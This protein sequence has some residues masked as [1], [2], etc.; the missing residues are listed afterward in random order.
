[1]IFFDIFARLL[2]KINVLFKKWKIQLKYL[3]HKSKKQS[4]NQS[5]KQRLSQPEHLLSQSQLKKLEDD[6]LDPR[7]KKRDR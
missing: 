1:L 4:P 2:G 7:I 3:S 6:Q 5:P